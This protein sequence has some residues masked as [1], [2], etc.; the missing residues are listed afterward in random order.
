QEIREPID[1]IFLPGAEKQFADEADAEVF[2]DLEGEDVPDHFDGNEAD[3]SDLIVEILALAI[4][5]YPRGESDSIESLGVTL[6]EARDNPFAALE[7]L[8]PRDAK[9]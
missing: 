8:K 4:D 2:V 3:L 1:R 9:H 6:D 7:A 5:P